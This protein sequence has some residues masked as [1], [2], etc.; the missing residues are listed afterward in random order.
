M[1]SEFALLQA[2]HHDPRDPTTWAILADWLEDQGDPRAELLHLWCSLRAAPESAAPKT[3]EQQLGHLL[4]RGVVPCVPHLNNSIGMTFALVPAGRFLMGTPRE[5]EGHTSD[6]APQHEVEITQPFYLGAY[7]VTQAQYRQVRRRNPSH[8]SRNGPGKSLV[9]GVSTDLFP[10]DN[11]SWEDALRFCELLSQRQSER[12]AG[13]CYRLPTEAEWEYAARAAGATR[14]PFHLGHSLSVND[15]NFAGDEPYGEAPEGPTLAR[16][17]QVGSYKPNA[18]GLYDMHGNLWEWCHDWYSAT[19]YQSSPSQ[20]PPGP[21]GDSDP[22]SGRVLRGGC[23]EGP[24]WYARAG[25]RGRIDPTLR[26]RTYGF[27]VA[28]T[29]ANVTGDERIS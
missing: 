18:L 29:A 12:R 26:F 11:V 22:G 27:R 14:A 25:D 3:T 20:D 4:A 6:E 8:F 21:E 23:Y 17:S 5:E 13:R 15:A 16:T 24:G 7:P 9:R 10:V 1:S 2:I 19:Y 28:F